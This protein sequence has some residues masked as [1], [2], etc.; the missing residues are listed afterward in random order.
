MFSH[1]HDDDIHAMG[2]PYRPDRTPPNRANPSPATD[3]A[4]RDAQTVSIKSPGF[5]PFFFSSLHAVPSFARAARVVARD[6]APLRC[7]IDGPSAS[8]CHGQCEQSRKSRYCGGGGGVGAGGVVRRVDPNVL[9]CNSGARSWDSTHCAR[10]PTASAIVYVIG[11]VGIGV[12]GAGLVSTCPSTWT[13]TPA[14][15]DACDCSQLQGLHHHRAGGRLVRAVLL[16]HARQS[17]VLCEQHQVGRGHVRGRRRRGHCERG[18]CERSQ[19]RNSKSL[20]RCRCAQAP[21]AECPL[22]ACSHIMSHE[23]QAVLY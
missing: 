12:P 13:Q 7:R 20:L 10:R 15:V 1:A 19:C 16:R 5:F 9:V 3:M 11:I 8:R 14:T 2:V 21:D 6:F 23:W 4:D 22:P 17:R 18:A